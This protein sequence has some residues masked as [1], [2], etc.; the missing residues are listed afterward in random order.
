MTAAA[1]LQSFL[2][3]R[4]ALKDAARLA[5]GAL[6]A[7]E[8]E[9]QGLERDAASLAA[10]TAKAGHDWREKLDDLRHRAKAAAIQAAEHRCRLERIEGDIAALQAPQVSTAEL[11]AAVREASAVVASTQAQIKAL[12]GA[13]RATAAAVGHAAIQALKGDL[14]ALQALRAA[15]LSDAERGAAAELLQVDLEAHQANLSRLEALK[16]HVK[17]QDQA[18]GIDQARATLRRILGTK[19]ASNALSVLTRAHLRVVLSVGGERLI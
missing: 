12:Q 14:S 4:E 7:A 9:A 16:D 2:E 17:A 1:E 5:T 11:D 18:A 3:Q 19:E 13:P 10:L 8:A 6:N 15:D